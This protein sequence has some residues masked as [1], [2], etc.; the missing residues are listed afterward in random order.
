MKTYLIVLALSFS[1]LFPNHSEAQEVQEFYEIKLYLID[2]PEQE[3]L[4]DNY[5]KNAYIP[6]LNRTGI[7]NIGVFKPVK[8]DTVH[9][10]KRIY[11]LTP[12]KSVQQFFDIPGLLKSD[13]QYLK[14]AHDYLNAPHDKS[15]YNRIET[16]FLKAFKNM[17]FMK[18]PQLKGNRKE[19]IYELRSYESATESLLEK[20]IHMFNEGGEIPLFHSLNFNAVFFAETLVGNKMPNLMY[21]TSF[22]SLEVRDQYW[23]AFFS[24]E[25]WKELIANKYYDNSVSKAEIFLL[26]RMPYSGI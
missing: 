17:P 9:Y 20:K 7:K 12:F 5:L 3:E 24:S 11:V 8:N 4:T 14:A 16:T 19:H 1:L 15:P 2:N 6:A 26:N 25:K 23:K 18:L 21:M 10:G 22:N 13:N